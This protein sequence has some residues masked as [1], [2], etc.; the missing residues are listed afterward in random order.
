MGKLFLE[1]IKCKL[2]IFVT[3]N[4]KP[5]N[6]YKDGLQR[7]AILPFIDLIKQKFTV[8]HLESSHDYRL[9][10][11]PNRDNRILYPINKQTTTEINKIILA[12]TNNNLLPNS[13]AVF[14]RDVYFAKTYKTILITDFAE[15]FLR[16]LGYADYVNICQNFTTIVV[17]N[18]PII[19]PNNTD[20]ATR[21][22]NFIDNAYFYKILLFLTLE[23]APE[24]IYK[25]GKRSEEFKRTISRLYEMNSNIYA[26]N[27]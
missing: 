18:I 16:E 5:D 22:I 26:T 15:L 13:I 24:N 6:I 7:D 9:D 10:K 11:V 12:L 20:L 23:D 3:S 17:E 4:T 1:L 27:C 8:L 25:S 14:G 2:F 19:T 21:V